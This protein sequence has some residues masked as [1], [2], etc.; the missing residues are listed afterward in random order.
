MTVRILFIGDLNC[1]EFLLAIVGLNVYAGIMLAELNYS[2]YPLL[3]SQYSPYFAPPVVLTAL[4]FMSFPSQFHNHAPW[5][6]MLLQ[7]HYKVAPI[8]AEVQRFWPSLGAQLLVLTAVLSPHLR[9]LLSQRYFL[10]LGKISFPLYL[11]HGSIMRTVL[12]WALFARSELVEMQERNGEQTYILMKYPIP[13]YTMFFIALPI[14]FVI[15]FTLTHIWT[16]K[17][18]PYF[19]VITKMAEDLMFGK[20]Q[21]RPNVLPVRQD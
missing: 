8:N 14:F 6:E 2:R 4:V 7:W 18:E 9:R 16:Q 5:S 19:G 17:V 3:F 12:A 10:W 13:G 1:A 15:L 11:L 20:K 21:E